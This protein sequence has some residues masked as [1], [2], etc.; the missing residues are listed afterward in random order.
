MAQLACDRELRV[1]LDPSIHSTPRALISACLHPDPSKRPDMST[2]IE[3]LIE[4]GRSSE[5]EGFK[6]EVVG[7]AKDMFTDVLSTFAKN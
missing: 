2:I 6:N 7:V 5:T 3:C 1:P 4:W